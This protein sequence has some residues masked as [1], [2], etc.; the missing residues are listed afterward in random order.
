MLRIPS[1]PTTADTVPA[2]AHAASHKLDGDSEGHIVDLGDR[3]CKDWNPS[4]R[5]KQKKGSRDPEV[6]GSRRGAQGNKKENKSAA[7]RFLGS[8]NGDKS[9]TGLCAALPL[10]TYS[11]GMRVL[12]LTELA[13]HSWCWCLDCRA[14][15]GIIDITA[16]K[17]L[18]E[19]LNH[20]N[21]VGLSIIQG[22]SSHDPDPP[23]FVYLPPCEHLLFDLL[24]SPYIPRINMNNVS[25]SLGFSGGDQKSAVMNQIREEA[26]MTNARQLIEVWSTF[27][28]IYPCEYLF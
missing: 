9:L 24:P 13:S 6:Y 2:N 26:A 17:R 18:G 23:C 27:T 25:S 10:L 3:E 11:V 7:V 5:N 4:L 22:N 12:R 28:P 15:I 1:S 14:A 19:S 16:G 8:G 21:D 20:P